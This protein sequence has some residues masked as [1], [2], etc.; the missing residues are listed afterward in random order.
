MND[1][2]GCIIEVIQSRTHERASNLFNKN[3]YSVFC[4]PLQRVTVIMKETHRTLV[5]NLNPHLVCVLCAGYYIDP[6]TI[7][8][9]LHSCKYFFSSLYNIN[10]MVLHMELTTCKSFS[11]LLYFRY[12]PLLSAYLYTYLYIQ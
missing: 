9:C 2:F 5:K 6:T 8:E 10:Y 1:L 12:P 11:D 7:V 3:I 4:L